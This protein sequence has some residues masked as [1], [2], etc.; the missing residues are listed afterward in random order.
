MATTKIGIWLKSLG[1]VHTHISDD[2][3]IDL[4]ALQAAVDRLTA[5]LG[6]ESLGR[7]E[8]MGIAADL[9][10]IGRRLQNMVRATRG[11]PGY[12]R[13]THLGEEAL[14]SIYDCLYSIQPSRPYVWPEP[15]RIKLRRTLHAINYTLTALRWAQVQPAAA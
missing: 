3:D 15:L 1:P 14:E 5:R 4:P 6:D 8:L 7:T 13:A 10:P 12:S 9:Q 11:K 2:H